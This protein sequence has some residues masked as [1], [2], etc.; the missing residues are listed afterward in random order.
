MERSLSRV[1]TEPESY[2]NIAENSTVTWYLSAQSIGDDRKE[3]EGKKR[4][5]Q[6]LLKTSRKKKV[7]AEDISEDFSQDRRH[8]FTGS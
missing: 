4:K 1:Q 8:H 3:P 7:F 5:G 6:N 2:K